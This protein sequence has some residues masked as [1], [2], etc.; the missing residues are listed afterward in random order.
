M[1]VDS[2]EGLPPGATHGTGG[3]RVTPPAT[4]TAAAN[5]A[6]VTVRV[7]DPPERVPLAVWPCAQTSAQYQR[8]SRCLP[9]SSAHPGKMLPELARRLVAGIDE[10]LA[11][12]R[13]NRETKK[14]M[15]NLQPGTGRETR[16]DEL[17]TVEEV[18]TQLGT[19]VR[20]VRRL[21]A[22]RRISYIKVGRYV[23]ITRRDLEAFLHTGRVE[24]STRR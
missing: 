16:V 1:R 2:V 8:T 19:K 4:P 17:L 13:G 18:A 10:V 23:R 12:S 20:F 11:G 9:A 3:P 24:T 6:P 21:I 22:E 5:A 14:L 15:R 7:G